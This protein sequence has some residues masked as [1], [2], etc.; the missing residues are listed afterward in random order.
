MTYGN[1]LYL[2]ILIQSCCPNDLGVGGFVVVGASGSVTVG[3]R[4]GALSSPRLSGVCHRDRRLSLCTFPNDLTKTPF[5]HSFDLLTS[6][7]ELWEKRPD[8]LGE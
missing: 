2:A 1:Q 7:A 4:R 6:Q 3:R 8:I 5:S